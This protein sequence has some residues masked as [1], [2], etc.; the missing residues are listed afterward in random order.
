VLASTPRT[1]PPRIQ[2]HDTRPTLEG[3]RWPVKRSLG[4][5]VVVECDLVR[6]GHEVLRAVVRHRAPGATGFAEEPM[7][8]ISP[9]RWR[10]EF[11]AAAIGFHGFQIEAWVDVFASWRDELERKVAGGQENLDSELAEG[12]ALLEGAAARLRG[13]AR[14]VVADAA[15]LL[16]TG[17]PGAERA[18]VALSPAV[19][20]VMRRVPERPEK[21]RGPMLEVDIDRERAR[22]GAWY[23]LFPRSFGGL[24]GVERA[25]PA[26]AELGFDVLYL[27][28][29]H[30]I[31]V[32]HRKGRNNAPTARPGE[33]GSPWAIG[34]AGGG[35]TAV[36]PE[37]GTMADLESL[38]AAGRAHGVEIA[39]DF[40]IQCSPDHPWLTEHPDWFHRRPDGTLKYAE[41][42]PKKYQ[43]IYNVNFAS[44][45]WRGLWDALRDALVFWVERGVRIFRVDNPHTKPIGFWQW[46]IRTVRE[47]HPD[48]IFLAEAFTTPARMYALAKA[49]FSQSYT[50]F[51][52]KNSVEELTGYVREL[53]GPASEFFRPNFFANTPDILHA[54]LQEGGRAAFE[55]RLILAATLSPS[56]GI[57]SGFENLEAT[58][59]R[60][61][62]EEYLD[63]EK[64]ETRDRALDG[65]LL[66]LVRR[67]NEI[68]RAAPALGRIDVRFLDTEN[69]ALIAYAKGRGIG[70]ILVCV[71]VD[72]HSAHEGIAMIPGDLD[73]PREFTVRDLVTGA[74]HRWYLGPNY[75]RL[76][77]ATTPA[78]VFVVEP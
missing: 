1:P 42:P 28:P 73:L 21:V 47:E 60:P 69:H 30:P 63:S 23:E 43:D 16:R 64:Y 26:L 66:P 39:L 17:A 53:A 72:P 37:L 34:G 49:G 44:E 10:G 46:L 8:Q 40:A 41:N 24:A 19:A 51:T 4:D 13:D 22:V 36:N 62:S 58:P 68:R 50:Y 52:W 31:G 70:A 20:E 6:D 5:T 65:P 7:T 76:D 45:D 59:V 67:L 9:D 56:Y 38:V 25:I 29:I 33:P 78:H 75:V 27:P 61:G 54:Y 12:A 11:A 48:V 77:P 74:V 35:H 55:A 3:G 71:N 14:A 57:Y 32:T 2:V 18:D 15:A